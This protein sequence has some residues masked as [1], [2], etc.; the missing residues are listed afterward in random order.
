MSST[1]VA[2]K[3]NKDPFSWQNGPGRVMSGCFFFIFLKLI[4]YGFFF[5]FLIFKLVPL[6]SFI[7]SGE[8]I[9]NYEYFF[10]CI[11]KFE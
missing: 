3:K 11:F 2:N 9:L 8:P 1:L 5:I 4:F 10:S 6:P 7:L